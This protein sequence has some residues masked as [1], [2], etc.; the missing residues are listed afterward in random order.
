MLLNIDLPQPKKALAI[1][2]SVLA[3]IVC[4]DLE[5]YI[6]ILKA[7]ER[8]LAVIVSIGFKSFYLA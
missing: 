6:L 3:L 2:V 7:I 1:A 8:Q 5:R 4:Y